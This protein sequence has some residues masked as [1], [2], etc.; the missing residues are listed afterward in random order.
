M[1]P[2]GL[3]EADVKGRTAI[4][5][6]ASRGIGREC[7]LALAKRGCNIVVAAKSVE[8]HPTLPGTI[9]TVAAECEKLGVK[10]LGVRVDVRNPEDVT[11]CIATTM[12]TFGRIDILINNAS[13]LWWLDITETPLSRYNL[14]NEVNARGSFLM[15][16]ACMPHMIAAGY[17]DIINMSPPVSTDGIGGRTAYYISKL[18]MT[19]VALGAAEEGRPHGIRANTL[20]PRT[21]IESLASTNFKMGERDYWRKATIISDSVLAIISRG[22][23]FSGNTL[24]DE[25]FLR[26]QG[27][28]DLDLVTYRV[29]PDVEPISMADM[30]K[31]GGQDS[32][33]RGKALVK[34]PTNSKL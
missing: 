3:F 4:I 13:A 23:D 2:A 28:T 7:A 21:V 15:T 10:A 31:F 14:I 27:C 6:G 19:L 16:Q 20:W 1:A 32:F 29:N 5:T 18:G 17:G 34:A 33:K 24:I 25:E 30:E 12:K 11:A 9:F 8:A 22:K 26:S